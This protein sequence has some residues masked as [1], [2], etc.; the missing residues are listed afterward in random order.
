MACPHVSG[1]VALGL[2][3]AA[4]L[5]RHF[6]ADEFKSLLYETA[7]PVDEYMDGTKLYKK[8]VIDLEESSPLM[9]F[10]KNEY[11]GKMGR[12]QVDAYAFL[13]AIGQSGVAMTFPNLYVALDGQTVVAPAM[14]FADGDSQTYTVTISD[15]S[16]A[17]CSADG[18]NLV[19][20][21][22]AAGQTDAVIKSS[23]GESFDFVIT[24]REGANGNGWL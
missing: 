19:F 1:V 11:K 6:T 13:S 3:Y 12:G 5:R 7:T 15:T 20:K 21:G 22:L 10:S 24:V 14:Y 23:G 16:V 2:S 4:K 17:E 8:Y 9:S 18:K